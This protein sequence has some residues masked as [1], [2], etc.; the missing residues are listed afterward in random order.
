MP[1]FGQRSEGLTFFRG[2]STPRKDKPVH[3][4]EVFG[5][6]SSFLTRRPRWVLILAGTD[7]PDR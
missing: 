5:D 4:H 3:F 1:C 7:A 2:R 6:L